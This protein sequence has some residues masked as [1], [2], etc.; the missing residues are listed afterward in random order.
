M[1]VARRVVNPL[2][3]ELLR[4]Q[5]RRRA[6][7]FGGALGLLLALIGVMIANRAGALP[8]IASDLHRWDRAEVIVRKVVDGDTI[9]VSLPD[10]P[11]ERV[12]VRLIGVD[13]PELQ[14]R[15][16]Y[17]DRAADYVR[18][19]VEGQR[20]LLRLQRHRTHDR[21]DRLLAYVWMTDTESL[22]HALVRDGRAY[23]D[24]R[25]AHQSARVYATA[26]TE[27]RRRGVGLWQAV[28]VDQMPGWRQRW[29]AEMSE[30]RDRGSGD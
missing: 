9:Q 17:A 1:G 5:L 30:N 12:T 10:R 2:L 16:H 23:A 20:V 3:D 19:R 8:D 26:E 15:E 6:W 11:D 29:L 27:A 25:S 18:R 4:R 21:Y 14:G 22:N 28:R 13:A 7:R 24:R